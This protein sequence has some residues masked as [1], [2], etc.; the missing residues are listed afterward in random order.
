MRKIILILV[1]AFFMGSA[2]MA[3]HAR[4]GDRMPDP[5]VRAERMTERMAKEYSLND[6]QKKQLL[7]ANLVFVDKMGGRPMHRRPDA[8]KGKNACDSCCCARTGKRHQAD[9][10]AGME[11][12]HKEM[13]DA[14]S[15]YDAQLQKILTKDQYAAYNKKMQDR[16]DKMESKGKEAAKN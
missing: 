13:K 6:T 15:A 12:K 7:E 1:A 8:G 9:R 4:R 16:K 11:K 3:Q 14:R 10:K 5:K 2:A